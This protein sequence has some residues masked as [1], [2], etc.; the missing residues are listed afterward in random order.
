MALYFLKI[1]LLSTNQ[2]EEIFSCILL[3]KYALQI[4][5]FNKS[6]LDNFLGVPKFNLVPKLNFISDDSV[7]DKIISWQETVAASNQNG[8]L[9]KPD[10]D[11]KK[12]DAEDSNESKATLILHQTNLKSYM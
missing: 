2:N 4:I 8:A 12:E 7:K 9:E 1:T 3:V 6:S 10:G 5:C 11:T